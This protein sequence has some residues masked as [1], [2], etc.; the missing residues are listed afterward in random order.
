MVVVLGMRSH[1]MVVQ[2]GVHIVGL[3][4]P[5]EILVIPPIGIVSVSI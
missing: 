5:K 2:Q 4:F 1:I 3:W